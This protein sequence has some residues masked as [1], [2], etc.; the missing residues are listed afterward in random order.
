M[1]CVTKRRTGPNSCHGVP[2]MAPITGLIES[3]VDNQSGFNDFNSAS[4]WP[5]FRSGPDPDSDPESSQLN[6]MG[7]KYLQSKVFIVKSGWHD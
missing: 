4:T 5:G 3:N 2:I 6:F 7:K 1:D